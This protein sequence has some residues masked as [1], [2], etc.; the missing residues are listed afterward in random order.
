MQGACYS[1]NAGDG[2][3]ARLP[4]LMEAFKADVES[5]GLVY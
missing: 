2:L 5:L 3:E 1:D 4:A